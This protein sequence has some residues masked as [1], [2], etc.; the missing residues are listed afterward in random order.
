MLQDIFINLNILSKIK[1]YDKIYI[2]KNN[3][4]SI[5]YNSAFQGLFRFLYN[6]SREK[7]L[8]NLILFYQNIFDYVDEVLNSQYLNSELIH[9]YINKDNEEFFKIYNNLDKLNYYLENSSIGIKN[10]KKTYS[11][12]IVTDSKLDIIINNINLYTHKISK[13]INMINLNIHTN[14]E[15]NL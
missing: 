9:D 4:I 1:P 6:N 5:E 10:L 11:S 13:K 2:N 7:N 15:K 3:L 14:K 12:D 8:T